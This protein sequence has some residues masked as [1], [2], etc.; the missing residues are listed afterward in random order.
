MSNSNAYNKARQRRRLAAIAFLSNI[1][2]DGTHR[3]TKWGVLAQ[4]HQRSD[5]NKHSSD[6]DDDLNGDETINHCQTTADVLVD[7]PDNGVAT[8]ELQTKGKSRKSTVR[9]MGEH[10]PDRISESSDSDSLK[11]RVFNT[12]IRDRAITVGAKPTR[13]SPSM[14]DEFR[15]RLF[16]ASSRTNPLKKPF[17]FDDK[18]CS[19]LSSNESL[20]YATNRLSRSVHIN[21]QK[22]DIKHVLSTNRTHNFKN[23]RIILLVNK[24]PFYM[25]SNIPF[26]KDTQ[27]Y[28]R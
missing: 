3:D 26:N 1:S 13:D 27:N 5:D 25:Y 6:D 23:D 19:D 4:Q 11:N 20:T 12:P 10:S 16:S 2:M 7:T 14:T 22:G 15:T 21:E 24:V 8:A 28:N 17:A 18:K 9:S